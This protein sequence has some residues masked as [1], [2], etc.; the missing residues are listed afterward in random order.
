M[1][2]RLSIMLAIAS[3]PV[4]AGAQVV[5]GTITERASSAPIVGALVTLESATSSPVAFSV[6]SNAQ[7]EYALRAP[8]AGRYRVTAKRI[9]VQRFV[10]EVFELGASETRR[11]DIVLEALVYRL[12]EVRVMDSDLCVLREP[13]RSVASAHCG[14]K[15]ERC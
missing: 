12:P 10:S 5:R 4:A 11:L 1:L 8:A 3:G 15:R 7:G 6:L 14:M 2:R 9:G 13:D